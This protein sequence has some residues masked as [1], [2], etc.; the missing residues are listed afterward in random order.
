MMSIGVL[1]CRNRTTFICPCLVTA[2]LVWPRGTTRFSCLLRK[3]GGFWRLLQ[4]IPSAEQ[5]DDAKLQ[6]KKGHKLK[7]DEKYFEILFDI[8][9]CKCSSEHTCKHPL[10]AG[11]DRWKQHSCE[12]LK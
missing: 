11:C 2:I 1:L 9:C 6:Q 8:A 4:E 12:I 10:K 3:K 5:N 7:M